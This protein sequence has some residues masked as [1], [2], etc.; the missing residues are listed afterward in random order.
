M[1]IDEHGVIIH[2]GIAIALHVILAGNVVI[3]NAAFR[4]NGADEEGL[5]VMIGRQPLLTRNPAS[6]GSSRDST[7][8]M[9]AL[10]Q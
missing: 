5:L 3:G 4:Q 2:V 10:G 8:G 6:A 9:S 1:R 7:L